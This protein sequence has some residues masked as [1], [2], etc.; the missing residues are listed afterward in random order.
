MKQDLFE[1]LLKKDQQLILSLYN[2]GTLYYYSVR[3]V[4]NLFK[5]K[6]SCVNRNVPLADIADT[7]F[8]NTA[9]ILLREYEAMEMNADNG[10]P[11]H[12]Q[13][14]QL[15]VEQG[16]QRQASLVT[17]IPEQSIRDKVRDVRKYL[18][19]KL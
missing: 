7:P 10:Y 16:S 1:I 18:K 11:Y 8:D 19:S 4:I 6:Y 15:V 14:I 2:Q 5:K 13:I 9:E 17:G 3:V 12:K